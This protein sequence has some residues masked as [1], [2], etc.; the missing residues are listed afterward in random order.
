M[1]NLDALCESI[2]Q[3]G[4]K[5]FLE[6]SGA[7]ALSGKWDWICVS[8]K[9]F[10]P[11]LRET[12]ENADELKVVVY[13]KSDFEW[14]LQHAQRVKRGCRLFLQPE[15]SVFNQVM[16]L[17]IDFVKNHPEWRISLQTHKMMQIP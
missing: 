8:P 10:K 6:T 7:Y 17:I 12:L 1:Y 14:A 5:T 9:K 16:P 13:H 4:V 15:Y 11:A 2:H 3:K